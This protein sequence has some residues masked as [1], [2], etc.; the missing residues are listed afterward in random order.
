[1]NIPGGTTNLGQ[2]EEDTPD[3]T[4]VP[5][6]IF[7]HS[8]QF[9]VPM[10]RI[11]VNDLRHEQRQAHVQWPGTTYKRA[12]SKAVKSQS[13]AREHSKELVHTTSGDLVGLRVGA[14]KL[15]RSVSFQSSKY[16]N[17][18]SKIDAKASWAIKL[19]EYSRCHGCR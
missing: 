10:K 5:Q 7:A 3:L 9:R 11:S 15:N 14:A 8:L 17:I 19:E 13:P 18:F 16:L 2:S 12:L 6:T 1:M 4:L